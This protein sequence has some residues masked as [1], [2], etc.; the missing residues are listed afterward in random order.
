MFEDVRG[1]N[2]DKFKHF[3]PSKDT[4]A[5][6]AAHKAAR[7]D[8]EL[9]TLSTEEQHLLAFQRAIKTV[10]F[11]QFGLPA[12]LLRMD[13]IPHDYGVVTY[14]KE[15][16]NRIIDNA[17][18]EINYNEGFPAFGDTTPIWGPIVGYESDTA[19]GLFSQYLNL[20]DQFGVRQLHAL[21]PEEPVDSPRRHELYRSYIMYSWAL[22]AKAFDLYQ[23]A[24]DKKLR[25]KRILSS[26][27][28]H[29]LQT[30][31]MI[32]TIMEHLYERDEEGNLVAFQELNAKDLIASYEKLANIQR[33]SLGLDTAVKAMDTL[34]T[35]ASSETIMR[36]RAEEAQ[37]PNA[38]KGDNRASIEE[39]LMS[40]D[41]TLAKQAQ[42]LITELNR[43]PEAEKTV[44]QAELN[45]VNIAEEIAG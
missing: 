21:L 8:G 36:L 6:M 13:M 4:K 26:T 10:P 44:K 20:S 7:E 15:E 30:E 39:L 40:E 27:N 33:L 1:S 16:L 31:R 41:S 45:P 34:P 14:S 32:N 19:F 22:R 24:A 18:I 35:G 11:N 28:T 42:Q 9:V 12:F 23:M 38:K 17:T 25:E 43:N 3:G 29:F 2:A 37:D 5:Q